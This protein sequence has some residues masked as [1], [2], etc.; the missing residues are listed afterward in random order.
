MHLPLWMSLVTSKLWAVEK[1]F[2]FHLP[3]DKSTSITQLGYQLF[4]DGRNFLPV[5]ISLVDNPLSELKILPKAVL[6]HVLY[7]LFI[8]IL[9]CLGQ[10]FGERNAKFDLGERPDEVDRD[11]SI[12]VGHGFLNV[13]LFVENAQ[14]R[15]ELE[16]YVRFANERPP[17]INRHELHVLFRCVGENVPQIPQVQIA[18]RQFVLLQRL[19][20]MENI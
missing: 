12:E 4:G 1:L 20:E 10:S 6:L 11:S 18:M 13:K 15:A 5:I 2:C 17:E 19:Y 8:L 3:V 9:L 7:L 14:E 16:L